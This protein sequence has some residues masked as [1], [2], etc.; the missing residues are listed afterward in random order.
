MV[1]R[2]N[3]H[4]S[5]LDLVRARLIDHERFVPMSTDACGARHSGCPEVPQLAAHAAWDLK[6]AH[7]LT[8]TGCRGVVSSTRRVSLLAG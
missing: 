7:G 4:L 3:P 5:R 1:A 6:E 8:A 2:D